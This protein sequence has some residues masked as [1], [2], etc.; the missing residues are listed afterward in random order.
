[1]K[2][3]LTRTEKAFIRFVQKWGTYGR[4]YFYDEAHECLNMEVR[5][6]SEGI[7]QMIVTKGILHTLIYKA[8]YNYLTNKWETQVAQ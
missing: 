8:E 1:M 5:N 6:T 3:E 4:Y 2:T 7:Q